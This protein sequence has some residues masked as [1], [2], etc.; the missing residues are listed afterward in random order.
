MEKRLIDVAL[1]ACLIPLVI[2]CGSKQEE[3]I[4]S[5]IDK[6]KIK[7]EI[8]AKENKFAELYNTGQLK[9]IG[10]Y[11]EDAISFSQN[12][13]PLVG[14]PAIIEYL[15]AGID[16]S[17]R[18][19]KIA[20]TTNEVFISNDGNQVVEIGYYNLADSTNVSINTGHY[21]VLFEKRNGNYVVLRDMSACD[22]P[23]Q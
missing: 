1:L 14:K 23:L 11:A 20:F 8:Q 6:D 10:Y 22:M 2:T 21:M 17:S 19:N 12:K 4:A 7:K 16:S 9:S 13:A 5:P 18:G 15:R 3:S